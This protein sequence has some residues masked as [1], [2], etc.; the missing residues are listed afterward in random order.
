M[1]KA[2]ILVLALALMVF[3]TSAFATVANT[4][5]NLTTLG[6]G[7]ITTDATATL[8]GFCH[9]PQYQLHPDIPVEIC[10]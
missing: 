3:A 5:H 2:V 7:T 1:K 6:S 4:K 8:C 10:A 9:I